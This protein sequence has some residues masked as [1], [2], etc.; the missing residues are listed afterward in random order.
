MEL[1]GSPSRDWARGLPGMQF[2]Q[3]AFPIG[4]DQFIAA[5]CLGAAQENVFTA[6]RDCVMRIT[7]KLNV[8]GVTPGTHFELWCTPM[9]KMC[10]DLACF[11][12]RCLSKPT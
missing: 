6:L 10:L 12:K 2:K 11:M 5:G 1:G 8:E 4:T 3:R 7:C 9:G